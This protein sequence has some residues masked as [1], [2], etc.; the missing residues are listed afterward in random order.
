MKPVLLLALIL[1]TGCVHTRAPQLVAIKQP[2]D[3]SLTCEQIAVEYKTNTEV[4]ANKIATNKAADVHDFWVGFL[5]WPGMADFQNADGNEANA[6]LDRNIY[7]KEVAKDKGCKEI[8][9]WPPQPERY[10]WNN[11]LPNHQS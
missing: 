4:A 11:Y 10:T 9:S 6:L 7:L 8:E 5:V 1:L 2:N 3:N